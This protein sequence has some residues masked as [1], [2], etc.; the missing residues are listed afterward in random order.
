[1]REWINLLED[2]GTGYEAVLY[3]GTTQKFDEFDFD[4]ITSSG[5]FGNGVYLSNDIGLA[6]IYSDGGEPMQ[7]RVKLKKVYWL[8]LDDRENDRKKPFR[9]AAGKQQLLDA[10]YDGVVATQ[11]RYVEVV[12]YRGAELTIID[13]AG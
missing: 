12:A 3:H 5:P 4:K 11:G 10:G 2:D 9:S 13:Q 8:D 6:R 1:M 7:V